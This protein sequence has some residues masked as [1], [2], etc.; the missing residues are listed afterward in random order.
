MLASR[1][2]EFKSLGEKYRRHMAGCRKDA[3]NRD[4][5][6]QELKETLRKYEKEAKDCASESEILRA[7]VRKVKET[8]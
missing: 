6:C 8:L 1:E 7:E 2:I 4:K 5:E 3:A